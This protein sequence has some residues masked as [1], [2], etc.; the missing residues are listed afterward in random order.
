MR[1]PGHVIWAGPLVETRREQGS[2]KGQAP[3]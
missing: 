1:V 2:G 3:A